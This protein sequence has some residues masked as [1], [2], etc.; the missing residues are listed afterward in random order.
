MLLFELCLPR[1]LNLW[2]SSQYYLWC[3]AG[4]ESTFVVS[5]RA[6]GN[7]P[8]EIRSL[9]PW[10]G[11]LCRQWRPCLA[12]YSRKS[13]SNLVLSLLFVL[14]FLFP[15]FLQDCTL[16]TFFPC[17]SLTVSQTVKNGLPH[18]YRGI[19]E[20]RENTLTEEWNDMWFCY[21]RR[22]SF[23]WSKAQARYKSS[24]RERLQISKGRMKRQAR[25]CL[26]RWQ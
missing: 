14:I 12:G 4:F 25:K 1:Q 3:E 15:I 18:Q 7:C 19:W 9:L 2:F 22:D 24:H 17:C 11:F 8:V 21:Q 5:C 10:P 6:V 16:C 13:L 23:D 20:T 26:C